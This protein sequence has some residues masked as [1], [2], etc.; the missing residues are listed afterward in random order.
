MAAAEMQRWMVTVDGVDTG[1]HFI[2]KSAADALGMYRAML[3]KDRI[4][5]PPNAV[6]VPVPDTVRTLDSDEGARLLK[7]VVVLLRRRILAE[8]AYAGAVRDAPRLE[9]NVEAAVSSLDEGAAMLAYWLA[10]KDGLI[11]AT[12]RKRKKAAPESDD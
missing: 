10:G 4:K 3:R 8:A 12:W 1:H 9:A 6:A 11:N 5:P 2:E 7:R